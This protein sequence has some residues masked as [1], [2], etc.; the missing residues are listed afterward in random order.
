MFMVAGLKIKEAQRASLILRPATSNR[1]TSVLR[2]MRDSTNLKRQFQIYP[3]DMGGILPTP[4]FFNVENQKLTAFNYDLSNV[5]WVIARD[6]G[7]QS[8]VTDIDQS[9]LNFIYNYDNSDAA[10]FPPSFS[11]QTI[12]VVRPGIARKFQVLSMYSGGVFPDFDKNTNIQS[13]SV[14]EFIADLSGYIVG[15]GRAYL[16]FGDTNPL[17][18]NGSP[19]KNTSVGGQINSSSD[20]VNDLLIVGDSSSSNVD[21]QSYQANL[22]FGTFWVLND[23]IFITFN[24]SSGTYQRAVK[25][26]IQET[27]FF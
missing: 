14:N 16:G 5:Q 10:P 12:K 17:F 26:L 19:F 6:M 8:V 2:T 11:N 7:V 23:P 25:N 22:P 18:N 1:M 27:T 21:G 20:I 13:F 4:V 15:N 3:T 9:F 24:V